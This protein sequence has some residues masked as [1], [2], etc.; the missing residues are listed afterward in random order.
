MGKPDDTDQRGDQSDDQ[1][2]FHGARFDV[3]RT[4]LPGRDGSLTDREYVKPAN[5]VVILPVL[6]PGRIV[7]IRNQRFAVGTELFEL[8]AGTIEAGEV[9]LEC[10]GRELE[11]ETGYRAARVEP[12]TQFFA[13]PGFCTENMHAFA[14]Y[15]LEHVG[16]QLDET[17]RIE[18]MVVSVDQA[19]AMAHDGRIADGKTLATLLWGVTFDLLSHGRS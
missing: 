4:Q 18:P 16:Q 13:S 12:M 7:M 6:D 3:Y 17:E 15:D 8:P 5:A 1:V 10:A 14:A 19:L 2:V 11:E 9:P